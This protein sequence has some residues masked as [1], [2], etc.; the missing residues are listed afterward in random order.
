CE[1][2]IYAGGVGELGLPGRTGR[3]SE[4]RFAE[5]AML[6]WHRHEAAGELRRL[7]DELASRHLYPPGEDR[8]LAGR[9]QPQ[10]GRHASSGPPPD[11]AATAFNNVAAALDPDARKRP[12]AGRRP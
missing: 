2:Q 8:H 10:P 11:R 9:P 12:T 7:I 6:W 4:V 1:A 3:A 5:V